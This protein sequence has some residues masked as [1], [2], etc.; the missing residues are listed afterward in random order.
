MALDTINMLFLCFLQTAF[1]V[2]A[3]ELAYEGLAFDD[4]QDA[5]CLSLLQKGASQHMHSQFVPESFAE[6][7]AGTA[8]IIAWKK[9]AP[10]ESASRSSGL[11]ATGV[12]VLEE[13]G[14][15]YLVASDLREPQLPEVLENFQHTLSEMVPDDVK[16]ALHTGKEHVV[17]L[18]Q[19][20]LQQLTQKAEAVKSKVSADVHTGKESVVGLAQESLQQLVQ[21]A[22]L[23][24]NKV[25]AEVEAAYHRFIEKTKEP[26]SASIGSAD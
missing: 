6:E 3:H 14:A 19:E 16:T 13:Q 20:S 22:Y 4:I 24:K 2:P 18:A 1:A 17:S 23:V 26:P 7:E 8:A 9:G 10:M 21:K 12:G 5:D 15:R 25:N 11:A